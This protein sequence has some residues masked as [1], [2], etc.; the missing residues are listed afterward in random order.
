MHF[1]V[2]IQYPPSLSQIPN[3][4]NLYAFKN[5]PL[6][7]LLQALREQ[8][9]MVER[10]CLAPPTHIEIVDCYAHKGEVD[11]DHCTMPWILSERK[12]PPP[13]LPPC[14]HINEHCP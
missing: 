14:T 8:R 10:M 3:S 13:P 6:Y 4:Y 12:I 1:C 2:K 11:D 9:A 7:G 5:N